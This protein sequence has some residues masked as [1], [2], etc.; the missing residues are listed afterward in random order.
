M[1]GIGNHT[2]NIDSAD[3][4]CCMTLLLSECMSDEVKQQQLGYLR[5]RAGYKIENRSTPGPK[6]P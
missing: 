2:Q 4:A 5:A 1:N 3:P 6:V